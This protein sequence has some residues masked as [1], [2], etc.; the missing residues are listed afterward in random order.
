[1]EV[2]SF[3]VHSSIRHDR[4]AD[5]TFL[6]NS[7]RPISSI[8]FTPDGRKLAIASGHRVRLLSHHLLV[9]LSHSSVSLQCHAAEDS[10]TTVCFFLQVM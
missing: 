10:L 3:E 7:G 9:P 2:S 6:I 1:M 4:M 5:Y 8:A